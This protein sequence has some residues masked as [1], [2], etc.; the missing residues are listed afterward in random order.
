MWS[1]QTPYI[2]FLREPLACYCMSGVF[3]RAAASDTLRTTYV[4]MHSSNAQAAGGGVANSVQCLCSWLYVDPRHRARNIRL[5]IRSQKVRAFAD[6]LARWSSRHGIGAFSCRF[7]HVPHFF[8]RMELTLLEE[9]ILFA[10]Y[11]DQHSKHQYHSERETQD[12]GAHSAAAWCEENT[13]RS[14]TCTHSLMQQVV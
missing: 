11:V 4:C 9:P 12:K 14:E 10:L 2:C 6:N 3:K 13:A 8:A 5:C 7:K 1:P